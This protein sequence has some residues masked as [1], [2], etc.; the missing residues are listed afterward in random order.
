MRD[1]HSK[2]RKEEKQNVTKDTKHKNWIENE[3]NETET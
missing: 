2:R 1:K 3:L